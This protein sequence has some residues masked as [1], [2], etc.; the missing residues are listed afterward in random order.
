MKLKKLLSL[1]RR[2]EISKDG[3]TY[4]P[5]KDTKL[6]FSS[7]DG[8]GCIEEIVVSRDDEGEFVILQLENLEEDALTYNTEYNFHVT[9]Y[10]KG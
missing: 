6:A 3:S 10:I 4:V 1:C 5:L 8:I 9:R 2:T 7:V